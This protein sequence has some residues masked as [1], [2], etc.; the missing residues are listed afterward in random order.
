MGSKSYRQLWSQPVHKFSRSF[1]IAL[2]L[3]LAVHCNCCHDPFIVGSAHTCPPFTGF[4]E[5]AHPS[6]CLRSTL[7][8][9]C[10]CIRSS[11]TS[12][13][14]SSSS[15]SCALISPGLCVYFGSAALHQIHHRLR[16]LSSCSGVGDPRSVEYQSGKLAMML[17]YR[18]R[19]WLR[20]ISAQ[21]FAVGTFLMLRSPSC[22]QKYRVSMCFVPT[23][24]SRNSPSSCHFVFQRSLEFPDLGT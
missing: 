16:P 2:H 20:S 3:A 5:L 10:F 19:D 12:T 14:S 6:R 18:S 11:S 8:T 22:I 21:F 9:V 17:M 4:T 15:S 13:S 23:D 1:A 7:T 24:P